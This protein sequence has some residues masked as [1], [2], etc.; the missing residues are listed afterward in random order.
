[1]PHFLGIDVGG[2]ILKS[3]L[4]DEA[5]N[6]KAVASMSDAAIVDHVGWSERDMDAMW[7]SV[8]GTIRQLLASTKVPAADIAGISFSAH[9]KGLYLVDRDGKPFRNGIISSDNRAMPVVRALKAEGVPDK[10]YSLSYQ[11]LWPSHPAAI[12]RWFKDNDPQAYGRIGYVLMAHD[13][14]RY[15]MTG[16]LGCEITNISGS[17]LFNVENGTYDAELLRLF[18]IEEIGERLPEVVGSVESSAGL[19]RQAADETGLVAGTPVYGGF[20]DVVSTA[21]CS[22]LADDSRIN[23]TM[24]TWTIATWTSDHIPTS[25]YPYTW[26][27]YCVP[28]RYFVHEGSPTSA[29][30][31]K[32]LVRNFMP[33]SAAPYADCD[34][35]VAARKPASTNIL[36]LPYLFSSNLGDNLL[37]GMYGLANANDFGDTVQA[38]YEGICFSQQVHLDRILALA[39][40]DKRLRLTGGPTKSSPWMQMVADIAGLPIEVVHVE[41]P[42]C[43]GAAVAAAVGTGVHRSFVEAMDAMCPTASLV[44]PNLAYAG[45]YRQKYE[46]FLALAH[47]LNALPPAP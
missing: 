22:G 34:A 33:D 15:R 17:N 9:G 2:S 27:H 13:W 47:T 7:R 36:F 46:R 35:L 29:A 25:D 20:F 37:G 3:G 6:E 16:H 38:V 14:I 4:Y 26:G 21:V 43:L 30:N 32:W 18:G 39:G 24:G 31:L 12:L 1:M 44:E 19:S 28:G 10:M 45:A 42:G 41:Q 23:V 40:R 11:Q 5:G 8:C